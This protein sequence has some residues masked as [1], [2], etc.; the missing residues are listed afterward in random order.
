[1]NLKKIILILSLPILVLYACNEMNVQ[2]DDGEGI[3]NVSVEGLPATKA[4][5]ESY[6]GET[7]LHD[8]QVF[9]FRSADGTL[10][11]KE[12]I[13]GDATSI[14]VKRLKADDYDVVVVCNMKAI[15]GEDGD[16]NPITKAELE[17]TAITLAMCDPEKGFV[18]YGEQKGVTVTKNSGSS[19]G[20]SGSAAKAAVTVSRFAARVRLVSVRNEIPEAYGDLTIDYV[21]LENG[22][23][24]WNLGGKI[25][26]EGKDAVSEPVNW[27]GRR[28]GHSNEVATED[29]NILIDSASDAM[30]A[31]QTFAEADN[32]IIHRGASE[33]MNSRL[34]TLPNPAEGI[35]DQETG[36]ATTSQPAY[37]RLVVRATFGRGGRSYYYPVTILGGP[38]ANKAVKRNTTYDV[39]MTIRGTGVNDPNEVIYHGNMNVE[40]SVDPWG[41]GGSINKLY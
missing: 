1:M 38:D 5:T 6:T 14:T 39:S 4:S 25:D 11:R 24:T 19:S 37:L 28:E 29:N 40:I 41:D 16:L 7:A 22:Y 20:Q 30:Y 12:A 8:T 17:N 18:M 3:M 23:G 36:P 15:L 10:Y 27:A 33:T 21:F 26:A 9:L 2:S 32:I 31:P 34:Y 35:S 13:A